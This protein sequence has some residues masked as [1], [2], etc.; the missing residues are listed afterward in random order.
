MKKN[1]N[2]KKTKKNRKNAN[3]KG[4]LKRTLTVFYAAN[5]V[6]LGALLLYMG[7]S[8]AGRY[9]ERNID[10]TFPELVYWEDI[11]TPVKEWI[12]R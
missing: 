12:E 10:G 2:K 9:T 4:S 5:A 8:V 3:G 6:L 1:R 7:V 11:F